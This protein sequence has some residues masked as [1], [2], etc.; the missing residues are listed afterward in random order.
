MLRVNIN[1]QD[2]GLLP[3]N[4]YAF[5]L[6][7]SGYSKGHSLAIIEEQVLNKFLPFFLEDTF[8]IIAEKNLF[9]L[10]TRRSI[11]KG[12]E[13]DEE[14]KEVRRE[15]KS[16]GKF[17]S[18]YS[19]GSAPALK[20]MRR[21]LLMGNVGSLNLIVDEFGTNMDSLSEFL[22]VYLEG[23]DKGKMK[24]KLIKNTKDTIRDEEIIGCVPCNFLAFGTPA[25]IFNGGKTEEK[26]DALQVE[27]YAR[28]SCFAYSDVVDKEQ[29]LTAT[30]IFNLLKNSLACTN[31]K[32]ISDQLGKLADPVN[33]NKTVYFSDE[34]SI[35]LI[36]YKLDCEA[37]AKTYGEHEEA[38][39]AEMSHRYFKVMKLS[40]MYAFI[41]N[42]FEVLPNHLYA[43]IKFIEDSGTHFQKMMIREKPYVRLAKYLAST[44][45]EVTQV[46]LIEANV[47]KGSESQ[48]RELITLATAY[49]YKHNI[50]IKRLFIDGIEFFKG[51]SL[52]ETNL[53]KL[54]LA[55]S[56]QLAEGYNP[57]IK[58]T[59]WKDLHI[60]TQLDGYHWINHHMIDNY[61]LEKNAIPG[62]NM[63][64]IDVDGSISLP[65]AQLLLKEYTYLVYTTKRHIDD[66]HRFRIVFPISHE[67]KLNA[68][69]FTEF[70][71]NVFAWLPFK[72]DDQTAQR[73]RKWLSHKGSYQYNDG[74]LLDAL[75]FIPKTVKA[76]EQ[77]KVILDTQSLTNMER[78]FVSKIQEGNRSNQ[79]IK[80][81]LMLVDSGLSEDV[82]QA[83]VLELNSKLPNKL[84]ETEI[85][86]TIMKSVF[87]AIAKRDN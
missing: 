59:S 50:I 60:L 1:S 12:T 81:A 24:E 84:D 70:M 13:F 43:A 32:A 30:E 61:R 73:S 19:E 55:C 65:T 53:D 26:F 45:T 20:Q 48:K 47:L 4:M 56:T 22:G 78:W 42:S 54:I 6:A 62:F 57:V 37:L 52:K 34:V 17:L 8:Q 46:D 23:Y 21:K 85:H 39:R 74:V 44:N 41:D 18:A 77:K 9:E 82:I 14:E 64:V 68:E 71:Q 72:V 87:K 2:R 66:S 3:I 27:G 35:E 38:K 31:L 67:L 10:I 69:D 76:E 7:G 86:I 11:K 36:Q 28:R 5:A 33:Y 80:Y 15:Y 63:I 79:L 58:N 83:K 40:G 51:E 25:G 16:G 29:V 49:G 75:Q